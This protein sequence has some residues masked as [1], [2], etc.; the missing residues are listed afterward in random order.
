MMLMKRMRVAAL[1]IVVVAVWAIMA[2]VRTM[3]VNTSAGAG[4]DNDGETDGGATT[5]TTMRRTAMAA[6]AMAPMP[7]MP[8]VMQTA[9]RVMWLAMFG[10]AAVLGVR[11]VT[12]F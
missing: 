1:R 11:V 7:L 4:D 3:L 12:R 8:M 10:R 5:T 9:A 2:S 6:V